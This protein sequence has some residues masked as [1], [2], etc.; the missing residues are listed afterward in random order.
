MVDAKD[1]GVNRRFIFFERQI[2]ERYSLVFALV[3]GFL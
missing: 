3:L 2:N 1:E